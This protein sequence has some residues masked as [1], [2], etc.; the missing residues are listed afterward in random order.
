MSTGVGLARWS[1]C[2]ESTST[3]P[4]PT[5]PPHQRIGATPSPS[6]SRSRKSRRDLRPCRA[7]LSPSSP[8][9]RLAHG[10]ASVRS[11]LLRRR[12]RTCRSPSP[13]LAVA[14]ISPAAAAAA[15]AGASLFRR[16]PILRSPGE[17]PDL[18]GAFVPS[19]PARVPHRGNRRLADV[20]RGFSTCTIGTKWVFASSF[21][22]SDYPCV[23]ELGCC[24]CDSFRCYLI[25]SR[26]LGCCLLEKSST[27]SP[28]ISEWWLYDGCLYIT[29]WV[30]ARMIRLTNQC[31][32]N[33]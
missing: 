6:P 10:V 27:V 23:G 22:P 4:T 21:S 13:A 14:A 24:L 12:G 19:P 25:S 20:H 17:F 1:T 26:R 3:P 7:L 2:T 33:G 29:N 15:A 8:T 30:C 28:W 16:L 32:W 11:L 31:V 18:A 5:D 9:S